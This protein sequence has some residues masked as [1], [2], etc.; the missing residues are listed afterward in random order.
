MIQIVK[1]F[2]IVFLI[3]S[4]ISGITIL[5]YPSLSTFIKVFIGATGV[6]IFFFVLYNNI[7]RYITQLNLEKEALQLSQLAEQNR[8]L[9]ECQKCKKMSNVYISLTEE[10]EFEC[11]EC[12]TTNKIMIDINTV[13]PT[14]IIYDK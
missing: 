4:S 3:S 7:L 9:A 1:S 6:Q 11:D 5:F 12:N 10:N 2:L 14:K 8:V 13:L